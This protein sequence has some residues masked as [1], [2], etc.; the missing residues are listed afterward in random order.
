MNERG[1]FTVAALVML[2][3]IAIIFRGAQE[4]EMNHAYETAD[5]QAG[6][7]L[8]NAADSALNEAAEKV[9]QNSSLLPDP[10]VIPTFTRAQAE[11]SVTQPKNSARLGNISVKVYGERGKIYQ[12]VRDYKG[13]GKTVDKLQPDK[14]KDGF[15]LISVAET[16]SE[17]FGGKIYRRSLGYV[18]DDEK[19]VHVVE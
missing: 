17:R 3:I 12:L 10:P 14:T 7:E 15:V 4:L 13:G 11:I 2:L 9:I 6:Y 16:S 19:I 5:Y 18:L 8:Q 1:F